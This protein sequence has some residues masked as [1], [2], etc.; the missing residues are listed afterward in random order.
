MF[1]GGTFTPDLAS[2]EFTDKVRDVKK[3][4][5]VCRFATDRCDVTK[6][7]NRVQRTYIIIFDRQMSHSHQNGAGAPT[8]PTTGKP[9]KHHQAAGTKHRVPGGANNSFG[10]YRRQHKR[11][12]LSV[13]PAEWLNPYS[14]EG[15]DA[16]TRDR[17]GTISLYQQYEYGFSRIF[18]RQRPHLCSWRRIVFV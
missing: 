13:L 12:K 14:T 4:Q 15:S 16:A 10:R 8:D 7:K 17:L 5:K 1:Y 2:T 9:F 11:R 18:R 3:L 6:N